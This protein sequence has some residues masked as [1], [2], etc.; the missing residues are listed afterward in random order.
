MKHLFKMENIENSNKIENWLLL[1]TILYVIIF[2][3]KE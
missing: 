2:K 3:N 1:E